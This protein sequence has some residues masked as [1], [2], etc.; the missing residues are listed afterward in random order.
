M[1]KYSGFFLSSRMKWKFLDSNSFE[2][3]ILFLFLFFFSIEQNCRLSSEGE[4]Y[5]NICER[6]FCMPILRCFLK[7]AGS[8]SL[9]FE[10]GVKESL[11]DQRGLYTNKY[12]ATFNGNYPGP[13][14]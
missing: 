7:T 11:V 5:N 8:P 10:K 14:V 9:P 13:E 12:L 4:L 1:E 6:R 3:N 2:M